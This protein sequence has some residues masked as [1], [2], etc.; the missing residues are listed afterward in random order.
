MFGENFYQ[1]SYLFTYYQY[2]KEKYLLAQ[3]L[4]NHNG[5]KNPLRMHNYTIG[6]KN[7]STG[8]NSYLLL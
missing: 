7:H 6:F 5:F 2:A 8:R 1:E 4:H 3:K